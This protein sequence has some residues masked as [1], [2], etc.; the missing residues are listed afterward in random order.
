MNSDGE[1]ARLRYRAAFDAYQTCARRMAQRL[2]SGADLDAQE[3]DEETQAIERL[4]RARR[5]F[6]EVITRPQ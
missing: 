4:A 3:I 2:E 5:A 6:L 1:I